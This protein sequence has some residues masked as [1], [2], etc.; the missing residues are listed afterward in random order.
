[1]IVV[2]DSGPIHYLVLIGDIDVLQPLFTRVLIPEAVRAELMRDRTP[3]SVHA[4]IAQPPSWAEIL[5]VRHSNEE[6]LARLGPGEHEAIV[7]A[8]ERKVDYLLIDDARGRLFAESLH[9][10]TV[11]TIGILREAAA[12]DLINFMSSFHKLLATN[13]RISSLFREKILK[14]YERNE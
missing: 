8:R 2:A 9:I 10:P 4:W 14:E 7:L 6:G 3:P 5:T 1:M 13:F 12:K 11:G